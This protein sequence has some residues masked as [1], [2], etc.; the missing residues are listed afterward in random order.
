[1]KT[2]YK[3]AIAVAA[4]AAI[5][6][7]VVQGSTLKPHHPL[8]PSLTLATL[9]TP[10]D[11]RRLFPRPV[12]RLLPS[13]ESSSFVPKISRRLTELLPSDLSSSRSTAWRKQKLGMHRKHRRRLL[14]L[15]RKTRRHG[16][17]SWK[18]CRNSACPLQTRGPP[19][20]RP[21]SFPVARNVAYWHF[22]DMPRRPDDVRSSGQSRHPVDGI[23]L[24][25]LTTDIG[26]ELT[27]IARTAK[28]T[29]FRPSFIF[30]RAT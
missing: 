12:R 8:M 5:G 30:I 4:G 27:R 11:L 24:P 25:V 23:T 10:K 7:S 26:D 13:A 20:W 18:A 16:S 15:E 17:F 28:P 29:T 19:Y 22:S 9:P 14:Q 3:F 1:M 2:R 21:F 6:G